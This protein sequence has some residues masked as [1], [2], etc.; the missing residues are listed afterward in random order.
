MDPP[1]SGDATRILV[2]EDDPSLRRLLEMR[3]TLDGYITRT[4]GDGL[5]A[6]SALEEWSADLVVTDVMMP[7]FS[8]LSLCRAMRDDP[9]LAA[10]PIVVLT[11]RCFDDDIAA[12]VALGGV[13]FMTKPYNAQALHAALREALGDAHVTTTQTAAEPIR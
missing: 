10:V 4:A 7:R 9:R 11:A 2:V 13:T 1:S 6:L 3:L 8:G 5:A 12:V